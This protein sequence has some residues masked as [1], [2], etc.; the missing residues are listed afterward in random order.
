MKDAD[1]VYSLSVFFNFGKMQPKTSSPVLTGEAKE[2]SV[3]ETGSENREV[4][5]E[6]KVAEVEDDG[7]GGESLEE[8][9]RNKLSISVL[10]EQLDA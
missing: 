8:K 1:K 10:I 5:H 4:L 3:I 2:G 6:V 7:E 9:A